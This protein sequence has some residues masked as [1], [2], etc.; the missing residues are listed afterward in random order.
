M[1]NQHVQ[2]PSPAAPRPAGLTLPDANGSLLRERLGILLPAK[3]SHE[4][5]NPIWQSVL[6][7]LDQD[8]ANG[9]AACTS[10]W[11]HWRVVISHVSCIPTSCQLQENGNP[12]ASNPS[13]VDDIIKDA[14]F[15]SI[16]PNSDIFFL[17]P[18]CLT[19]DLILHWVP[20]HFPSSVL[21]TAPFSPMGIISAV[22][23]RTENVW[24][25][26]FFA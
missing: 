23:Q 11:S 24:T 8:P 7:R 16:L 20:I 1:K 6:C 25:L 22:I 4:A 18:C 5:A 14:N 10:E 26:S 2:L 19:L 12:R 13:E 3:G 21:V 9:P 17:S 15:Q